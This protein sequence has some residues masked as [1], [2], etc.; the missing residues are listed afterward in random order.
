MRNELEKFVEQLEERIKAL[1]P[2]G[3]SIIVPRYEEMF[4]RR[5][6]S[7]YEQVSI[8]LKAI[9]ERDSFKEKVFYYAI[10]FG[11]GGYLAKIGCGVTNDIGQ[12]RLYRDLESWEKQK[13]KILAKV[14]AQY[15]HLGYK[16][17]TLTLKEGRIKCVKQKY[18][19]GAETKFKMNL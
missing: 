3:S 5:I 12:A 19:V 13:D 9:L 1:K 2:K 8:K 10:K 17:V 4:N 15:T 11:V 6:A 14:A 18:A 7:A 16:I